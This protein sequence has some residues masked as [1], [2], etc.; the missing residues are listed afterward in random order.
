MLHNYLS[1]NTRFPHGTYNLNFIHTTTPLPYNG[2]Q[3]RRCWMHDTMSYY[4]ESV[5]YDQFDYFM[6]TGSSFAY[7]FPGLCHRDSDTHVSFR[8]GEPEV[9][10]LFV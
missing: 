3:N 10:N 2:K 9:H 6:R 1:A 8:S 5:L 4:G 7:D